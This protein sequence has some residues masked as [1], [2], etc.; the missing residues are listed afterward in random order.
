MII[1]SIL[2]FFLFYKL[3]EYSAALY[4][5]EDSPEIFMKW[6][7]CASAIIGIMVSIILY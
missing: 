6:S 1:I 7:I 3:E 5:G 4:H 2:L